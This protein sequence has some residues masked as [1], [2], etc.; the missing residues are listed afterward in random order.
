M[1][2]TLRPDYHYVE[3][4]EDFSDLEQKLRF[5]MEHPDKAEE[6]IGHAHEYVRQVRDEER[7]ELLQLMVMERY[8]RTSGQWT[9]E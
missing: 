6:I 8:F 1:E 7:E 3:V 4:R 9:D 5:Y 2:G